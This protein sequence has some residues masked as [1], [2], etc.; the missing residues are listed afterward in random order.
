MEWRATERERTY[1][2]SQLFLESIPQSMRPYPISMFKTAQLYSDEHRERVERRARELEG[3]REDGIQGDVEIHGEDEE[4]R[5]EEGKD[6]EIRD[7][8][9]EDE[10]IRDEDGEEG[11]E[12]GEG[13]EIGNEAGGEEEDIAETQPE[14][15]DE[16][17]SSN[18]RPKSAKI[19]RDADDPQTDTDDSF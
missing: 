3:M 14:P 16:P 15:E 19:S 1:P 9:G 17:K 10:E 4:V 11:A 2:R 5:D 13:E 7:E 6:E 12:V 18:L 8:D